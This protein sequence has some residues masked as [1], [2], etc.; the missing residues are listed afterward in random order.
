MSGGLHIPVMLDEVVDVMEPNDGGLYVDGT[1]GGGGY[2]RALLNE[3][4]CRVIGIDRD[5]VAIA[6]ARP[7]LK[8]FN[9]R[10]SLK[11]GRFGSMADLLGEDDIESV[12]GIVLDL[13]VSS[14]QLDHAERGF[15]F[16]QD[17][18][19]DMRMGGEGEDGTPSAA[20]IVN[21]AGESDLADI[22]FRY[23]EERKARPIA[24]AIVAAR[25]KAPILR[26]SEL[27]EIVERVLGP[28]ARGDSHPATRSFQALRIY[29]N[30]ELD[31][32]ASALHAAERLL[33]PG[34]RL[35][36]VSFHSLEDRIVKTFLATR[37]GK[38]SQGS[39]HAPPL[40]AASRNPSF[41]LLFS[42]VKTPTDEEVGA[43]PRARSAKMRGAERTAAPQWPEDWSAL[44]LVKE[45]KR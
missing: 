25:A 33:R 12:D 4:D 29:V 27:A 38:A 24:R 7:M 34:G 14:I 5:T 30:R 26:T 23:G 31:E 45:Y 6:A 20:D 10:L 18:P 11:H 1:F 42:G 41:H 35:I 17:G 44:G 36:V 37:G 40:E 2:A 9:G 19:L 32:L 13:G 22:L 39:R 3:A 16:I 8:M 43:N 28:S 21:E 15:S